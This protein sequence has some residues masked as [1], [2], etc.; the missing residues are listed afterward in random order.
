MKNKKILGTL[1]IILPVISFI[2]GAT[3]IMVQAVVLTLFA[4]N[5]ITG[6]YLLRSK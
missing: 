6:V 5:I 4:V 2:S 1:L 3:G